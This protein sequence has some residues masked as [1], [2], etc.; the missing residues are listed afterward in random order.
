MEADESHSLSWASW[1]PRRARSMV[2]FEGLSIR[3]ASS[4]SSNLS[5]ED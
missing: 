4:V 2:K 5:A 1:R 3:A